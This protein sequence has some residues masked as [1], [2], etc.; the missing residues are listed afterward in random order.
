[1]TQDLFSPAVQ[2][3]IGSYI[4]TSGIELDVC[5]SSAARYDWAE[6][7]LS[8]AYTGKLRISQGMPAAI[9]LGYGGTLQTVLTGSVCGTGGSVIIRDDMTKLDGCMITDTYIDVTPQ[10]LVQAALRAANVTEYVIDPTPYP[11][12]GMVAVRRKTG[13]QLLEMVNAVW[14]IAVKYRFCGGVFFW[15]AAPEQETI[16]RL[17]H[18]RNILRLERG[19]GDTW[20]LETVALPVRHTE[21]ISVDAP[22]VSGSYRVREVRYTTRQAGF[23]R[24][25]LILEGV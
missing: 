6:V 7:R 4:L 20:E 13:L 12:R 22:Q 19:D 3:T 5:S 10:E 17:E 23:V 16:Y 14:G 15:G 1:M 9:R 8:D 11:P 21:I 25:I 2:V 18:G 24:T